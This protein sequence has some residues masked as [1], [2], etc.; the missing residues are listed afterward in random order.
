VRLKGI[1]LLA[2]EK[3]THACRDLKQQKIIRK[4]LSESHFA[5]D[6]K[7]IAVA[8]KHILAV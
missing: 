2:P 4:T 7:V 8:P 3:F 1:L 5:L 6:G